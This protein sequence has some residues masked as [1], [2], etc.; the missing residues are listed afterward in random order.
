VNTQGASNTTRGRT[1]RR[2]GSNFSADPI[3]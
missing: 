3:H 2:C 1:H